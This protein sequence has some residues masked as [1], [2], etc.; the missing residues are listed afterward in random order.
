MK[1]EYLKVYENGHKS[2]GYIDSSSF[3]LAKSKI[4]ESSSLNPFLI[5]VYSLHGCNPWIKVAALLYGYFSQLELI[6][7]SENAKEN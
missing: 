4:R 3:D 6:W 7:E 1:F 5:A 2:V